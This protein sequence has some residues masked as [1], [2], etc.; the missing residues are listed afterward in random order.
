LSQP[1]PAF[2][3]K[4]EVSRR[5]AAHQSHRGL[6]VA[7]P[8]EPAQSWSAAG[9]R[10]AMVAARVAAR[11]AQAPS[12]SQMQ[13]AEAH[14]ALR[15]AEAATH[16]ALEANVAAQAVLAGLEDTPAAPRQWEPVTSPSLAPAMT[17][18]QD[19]EP[20]LAPARPAA[21]SSLEAW[22]NEYSRLH[23]EP[24]PRLRPAEP[25]SV[26]PVAASPRQTEV[27]T[28]STGDRWEQSSRSDESWGIES[29]E[30]VEPAQPIHANLIEFPRELVATRKMR[31]RRAEG[32][33]AE[34]D[35]ERQ[36]SIFEVDPGEVSTEPEIAAE[37][38]ASDWQKPEWS[39]IELEAQS[40]D[41]PEM[42][43]APAPQPDL[44]LA[45]ISRRFM[46]V[47]VDGLLILAA[48]L[49]PALMALAKIGQ[50]P[51]ARIMELSAVSAFLLA[52]LIYQTL[53][54]TLA[55]ATPG[56]KCARLSLCTF[57]GQIPTRKQLHTRLGA[58]LL[59]VVPVGL[60]VAWALFDDDH[61]CWHDRLSR[62]YLRKY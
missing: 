32:P 35:L 26:P 16:A 20:T 33:F 28:S 13:A 57:D 3:W 24:D 22:E 55:E 60:G 6:S 39:S 46:S 56:M 38:P 40:Q 36:L 58:L 53:F 21:P 34:E 47:L 1:D 17:S 49:L 11:Y 43:D 18:A 29:I 45:P 25:I 12:F 54:L 51:A 27:F 59:S 4:Q 44:H 48:L 7:E 19:W 41:E 8:A 31:P 14:A 62:T 2:S 61:L 50:P 30:P 10:A 23:W 52:G 5:I 42:Q 37:V 15:A 9:S